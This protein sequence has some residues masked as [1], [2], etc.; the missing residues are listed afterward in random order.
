MV[1]NGIRKVIFHR[2]DDGFVTQVTPAQYRRNTNALPTHYQRLGKFESQKNPPCCHG[3]FFKSF[4]PQLA[5]ASRGLEGVSNA[6]VEQLH[7][8]VVTTSSSSTCEVLTGLCGHVG[9]DECALAQVILD[10]Q[11]KLGVV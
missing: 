5:Y 3:G 6:Q 11:T 10:A 4:K 7:V 8:G 9:V 2:T 1:L